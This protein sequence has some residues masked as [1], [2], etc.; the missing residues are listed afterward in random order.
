MSI[1]TLSGQSSRDKFVDELNV[2]L[3]AGVGVIAVRTREPFVVSGI[4]KAMAFG[5]QATHF[6]LWTMTNGW[7]SFDKANPRNDPTTDDTVQLA[8]ALTRI[9]G[10]GTVEGFPDNGYY[11]MMWPHFPL[12]NSAVPPILQLLAEMAYHLPET[13]KRVILIVPNEFEVPKELEDCLTILDHDSPTLSELREVYDRVLPSLDDSKQPHYTDDQ[14]MAIL[15]A[16]AGMTSTEFESSVTQAFVRN[17]ATLPDTPIEAIVNDVSVIKTAV[18]KRSEVLELMEVGTMAEVGG[19]G[20]LKEW[21]SQR[22]YAFEEEAFEMGV[23]RPKGI[24]LIGPPG[25]GKSL[26]G[27]ATSHELGLPLV[28][29]DV[30]R[31]FAGLVGA[32]EGRTR[33][34]L[35][36]IDALAPCCVLVDEV[37]KAFNMNSGGGDSGVGM[38]VLGALLTHMQ[39]SKQQVFWIMTANRTQGLPPELLRKGRLDEVFSVSVPDADERREIIGIHLSKRGWN[40]DDVEGLDEVV[41]RSDGFVPAEIEAAV[42]EA[43]TIH[44]ARWKQANDGTIISPLTGAIINEQFGQMKKLSEA[45]AEQF[46]AMREWAENNARPASIAKAQAVVRER[47]RV[48]TT[49]DVTTKAPGARR[50]RSTRA[51]DG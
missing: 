21:M 3:S 10:K 8:P 42:K 35:K 34:A 1:A 17:R 49:T 5:E 44:Y 18:I 16:G 48:N 29:F 32:S 6:K 51:L 31:V 7:A 20:N 46:D 14:I 39:E 45:F 11:A 22:A 23:D 30:S 24:A 43:I 26:A 27:K 9:V 19:L 40:P 36:M 47:T 38:R 37:D 15:T 25:T 41:T 13:D 33:A 12:K 28:K 50:V 4:I 2:L